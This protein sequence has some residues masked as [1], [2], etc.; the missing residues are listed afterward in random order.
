M[1]DHF[2]MI[3]IEVNI[4]CRFKVNPGAMIDRDDA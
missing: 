4:G 3:S 1:R 2:P